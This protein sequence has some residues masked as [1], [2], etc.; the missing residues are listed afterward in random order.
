MSEVAVRID[1]L[2]DFV[3]RLRKMDRDAARGLRVAMN[4]AAQIVVDEAVRHVPRRT[5]R[6]AASIRAQSTMTA[7][8]VKAGGARVP[9]YPWLDF[10]GKVGRDNTA[11][12]PFFKKG[13]YI[14]PAYDHTRPQ[15]ERVLQRAILDVARTAGVDVD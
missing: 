13:R 8:R 1:G 5:G 3:R 15:F 12:R 7:S 10:G 6:A 14:Y 11:S 4:Q 9:Y 2:S